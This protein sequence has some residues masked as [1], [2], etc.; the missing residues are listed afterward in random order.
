MHKFW[1]FPEEYDNNTALISEHETLSYKQLSIIADSISTIIPERS[2]VFLICRNQIASIAGYI[3]FLRKRIVPVLLNSSVDCALF[4]NLTQIYQPQYIWCPDS[5]VNEEGIYKYGGYKLISTGNSRPETFDDLAV[6]L[7]TSGSTGSSKLVRLSYRN[8]QANTDSI[9]KFLGIVKEDKAIT[10]LPMN[11][12]YGLSIIQTH[13]SSGAGIIVTERSFF[14]VRFWYFLKKNGATT[15]GAV[16]YLYSVLDKLHFL[17]ME[18]PSLK[19][20]TQAGGHLGQNLHERIS[21]E[22]L[23]KGIKFFVMYGAT[24]ATARMS[25]LPA[26]LT[27]DKAGSIGIP[28]PGGKFELIDANGNVITENE[29]DGELVYYGPNVMLGYAHKKEDTVRGDELHGR[30]ETGD[31]AKR[32]SDGF[33]YIIGRKTRFIKV[34]G[35]RVSL[36][37]A[38]NLLN[39]NGFEAACVGDDDKILIYTTSEKQTEIIDFISKKTGLNSI[40][41]TV[42]SVSSIPRNESGKIMYTELS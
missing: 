1:D 2:F 42:I 38:E 31:L 23:D 25:Y 14:D 11:Y 32:D 27:A 13:L 39:E 5:F 35:N 26:D 33:Y 28:I 29:R 24:E 36:D 12:A 18:L 9:V 40:A 34:F 19:Y 4:E 16:P 21:K 3:G 8:L 17:Q 6:L 22:L 30:L 20:I 7:T 10:T 37:E 15:F 41:F